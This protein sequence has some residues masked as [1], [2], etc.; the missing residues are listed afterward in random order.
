[1]HSSPSRRHTGTAHNDR[2]NADD[3]ASDAGRSTVSPARRHHTKQQQNRRKKLLAQSTDKNRVR[4][5]YV[6]ANRFCNIRFDGCPP[7]GFR[8]VRLLAPVCGVCIA[9]A[10]KFT[11]LWALIIFVDVAVH[12]SFAEGA[13]AFGSLIAVASGERAHGAV[14]GPYR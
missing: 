9:R 11:V 5:I 6:L 13:R 14:T 12:F 1:M 2:S 4:R 8:L 10:V 7:F 3:D